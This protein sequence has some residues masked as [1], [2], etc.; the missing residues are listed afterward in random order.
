MSKHVEFSELKYI[1]AVAEAY[2]FTRAAEGIYV[3]QT[4]LGKQI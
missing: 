1:S 4:S 2:N 3:S